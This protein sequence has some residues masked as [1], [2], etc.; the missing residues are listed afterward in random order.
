MNAGTRRGHVLA[1]RQLSVLSLPVG[2]DGII[3]GTDRDG[4]SAVLGIHHPLPY[5]I[6]LV[7]GLWAAQVIA[8]RAVATG[9]R[10]AVET[11]RAWAWTRLA[12]AAGGGLACITL[13]QVGKVPP[14]GA[15]LG[16]PVLVVR[17]CGAQPPRGRVVSAS[18]QPVVTL[19]PFLSPAATR[20]VDRASLVGIQRVSPDEA[21]RFGRIMK[22][23]PSESRTLP[24]LGED[25]TLWCTH[26]AR[27]LVRMVATDTE[28]K[29]LGKAS[30]LD[31][32]R[33]SRR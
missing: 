7:G 17:D 6:L 31:P 23:P 2:D 22:L 11:A 10:V 1:A 24:E 12:A 25:T 14:L 19:L 8:L 28:T 16:N 20:L 30:R 5:E 15:S 32:Q 33:P 18:W 27:Q 3:I 29:L 4:R 21:Q 26:A 13:H 9:A